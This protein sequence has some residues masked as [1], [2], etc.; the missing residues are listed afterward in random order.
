MEDL[1]ISSGIWCNYVW[2][3]I[4]YVWS[5]ALIIAFQVKK[6]INIRILCNF[7]V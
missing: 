2:L 3:K 4:V 1:M 7:L 6:S 5:N